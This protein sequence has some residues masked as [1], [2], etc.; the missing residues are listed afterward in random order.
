MI[1]PCLS[2]SPLNSSHRR[3]RVRI[4]ILPLTFFPLGPLSLLTTPSLLLPPSHLAAMLPGLRLTS[5]VLLSL[6]LSASAGLIS[7]NASPVTLSLTKQF[8]LTGASKI[9]EIDQARAKALKA[10]ATAKTSRAQQGQPFSVPAF[11]QAFYY[12][13]TVSVR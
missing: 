11:N 7:H 3:C 8:N 2:R 13:T 9:L 12:S 1:Q 5:S 4:P 10:H 6:A